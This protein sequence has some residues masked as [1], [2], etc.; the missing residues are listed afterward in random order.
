M[1]R[2][3]AYR[4]TKQWI[5]AVEKAND[6]IY[7]LAERCLAR[8]SWHRRWPGGS[9]QERFMST[10]A[11]GMSER[12]F[13]GYKQSGLGREGGVEGFEEFLEVKSIYTPRGERR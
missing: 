10:M 13:G 4:L 11:S 9:R 8:K 5:E 12:L 1:A 6:S 7:D 3:Y 2:Y